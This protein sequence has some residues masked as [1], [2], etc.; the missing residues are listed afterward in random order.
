[1]GINRSCPFLFRTLAF[2]RLAEVRPASCG[3]H[4]AKSTAPAILLTKIQLLAERAA[5]VRRLGW[6]LGM[7]SSLGVQVPRP[8]RWG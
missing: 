6:L 5:A 3:K 4:T 1:M 7:L 8:T 2:R